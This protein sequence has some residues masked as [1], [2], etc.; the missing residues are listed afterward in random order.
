VR[1]NFDEVPLK[2]V[3]MEQDLFGRE[4]VALD[5]Y[6]LGDKVLRLNSAPVIGEER[7]PL[8]EVIVLHDI[9]AEAAVDQAKT[10]FIKVISHE[11]RTPLTPICGNV[12]LLLR[13]LF[14]EL[15]SE[16]RE[17]LEQVRGRADQMKDLVNNIIMVASIEANTL[18][19]E[20]EPQDLWIAVENALAPMRRAFAGKGIELRI[21]SMDDI[22]LVLADREQLRLILTQ[23]LD[24]ARRYTHTGIVTVSAT[25]RDGIVQ[26]DISDTGPGIPLEEQNRLFTRFHRIEGNNSPERGSGLGLAITRQLVERQGGRVWASSEVGHGSTFSVS[27][28]IASNH[29]D[30]V[31]GQNNADATA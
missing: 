13:G 24:N 28:P 10:D 7:E 3:E 11:L 1:R 27:L 9:S 17:T 6:Q 4:K 30:A 23:L 12:E 31:L 21:E 25:H 2:R 22:P 14:G 19:T 8:G 18:Q 29:A 16:Q 26:F 5:H 20:P 15:S